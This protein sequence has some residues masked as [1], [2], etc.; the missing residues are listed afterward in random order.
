MR[1]ALLFLLLVAARPALAL[2]FPW[3]HP[4]EWK[5][6]FQRAK[7]LDRLCDP[8]LLANVEAQRQATNQRILTTDYRYAK[9]RFAP[10]PPSVSVAPP[11][12]PPPVPPPTPV[13]ARPL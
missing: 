3:E 4:E 7:A 11:P 6:E 12:V 8:A 5:P 13:R 10:R 9:G 1:N 2:D